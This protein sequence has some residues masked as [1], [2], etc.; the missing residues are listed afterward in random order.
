MLSPLRVLGISRGEVDT[1]EHEIRF[2]LTTAD[3]PPIT[4]VA[5]YGA[6]GQITAALGRMLLELAQLLRQEQVMT[7]VAAE[8]VASSLI[9]R[10][11]WQ[12]VVLMQLTTPAGIPYTFALPLDDAAYIADQLK[13]ESASPLLVA[14]A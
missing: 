3:G 6:G 1:E 5:N 10:D 2:T 11:L 8:Q 13:I 14:S 7:T 9:Q 12:N 4:L